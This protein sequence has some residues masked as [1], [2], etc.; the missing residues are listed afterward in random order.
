[1]QNVLFKTSEPATAEGMVEFYIVSLSL[2]DISE[3]ISVVQ[4]IH[5]WWNNSTRRATLDR[6]FASPPET[7]AS[8]SEA[9]DRY[10]ALKI[11]RAKAGFVHSFSWDGFVG[12]PSNYKLIDLA[13]E[14][15]LRASNGST[16]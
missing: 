15:R 11:H 14:P 3:K 6:E 5:G 7:F 1:M 13:A 8:F 16:E 4:E 12:D 10:C 9:I 2:R